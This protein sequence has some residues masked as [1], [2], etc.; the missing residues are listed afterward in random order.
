MIKIISMPQPKRIKCQHCGAILE[1]EASDIEFKKDLDYI[2]NIM[3]ITEY[4]QCPYC[5]L[6]SLLSRK[7]Y[8]W[9]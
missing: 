2:L 3:E 9:D 5:K 7:C 8:D 1:Y 4:I 6:K